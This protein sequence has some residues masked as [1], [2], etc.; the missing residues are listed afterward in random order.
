[1]NSEIELCGG[2]D[3]CKTHDIIR[4]RRDSLF[5]YSDT[6]RCIAYDTAFLK[7]FTAFK[8]AMYALRKE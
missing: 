8:I 3:D 4:V 2:T 1:L 6:R 5:E 7:A